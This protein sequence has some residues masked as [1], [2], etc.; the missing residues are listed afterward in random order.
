MSRSSSGRR[1]PSRYSRLR[2][3]GGKLPGI[4]RGWC[5]GGNWG[6]RGGDD[7]DQS[8]VRGP[9]PPLSFSAFPSPLALSPSSP[10]S[11]CREAACAAPGGEMVD[12]HDCVC[13]FVYL[14]VWAG[15]GG[16]LRVTVRRK[17]F[18]NHGPEL[19]K[20]DTENSGLSAGLSIQA[21]SLHCL[22]VC[23]GRPQV[24]FICRV[25]SRQMRA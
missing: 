2:E 1:L 12:A 13:V 20:T 23:R 6:P 18:E 21:L 7:E 22:I 24:N 3:E 11:Q 15:L 19:R 10:P 17:T 25:T 5:V 8:G 14:S 9:P 16:P 4:V